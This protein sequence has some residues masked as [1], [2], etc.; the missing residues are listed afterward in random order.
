MDKE[1]KHE[2]KWGVE[3]VGE[4]NEGHGWRLGRDGP[5]RGK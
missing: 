2:N 3:H 4:N 1:G 5:G